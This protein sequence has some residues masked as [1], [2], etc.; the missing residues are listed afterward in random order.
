MNNLYKWI[1]QHWKQINGFGTYIEGESGM[2]VVV[3]VWLLAEH[4][5]ITK[6]DIFYGVEVK[7]DV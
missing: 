5:N 7:R 6:E 3:P 1:R 2:Y 4:M